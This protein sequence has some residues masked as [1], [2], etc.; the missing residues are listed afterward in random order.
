MSSI[1][2]PAEYEVR[3]RQ[4]CDR[5]GI[6]ITEA[7]RQLIQL[8]WQTWWARG[9]AN[10]VVRHREAVAAFRTRLGPDSEVYWL[11]NDGKRFEGIVK[12]RHPHNP[13]MWMVEYSNGT[14]GDFTEA[15][16]PASL[17]KPR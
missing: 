14:G 1:R 7:I 9:A 6:S 17:L 16:V 8:G 13:K 2:I 12:A 4:A 15:G 10:R 11:N 5:R 3:I